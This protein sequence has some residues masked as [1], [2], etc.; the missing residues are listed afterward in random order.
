M[1]EEQQ[2]Q[3]LRRSI[4]VRKPSQ[5]VNTKIYFN[6]NAVIHPIQATCSLA[7]YPQE[8]VV[9]ISNLDQEYIPRTY[10]E[11]MELEEWRD[12]V[13]DEI[14]AMIKNDT[15]YETELPKGKKA[16]H[17]VSSQWKARKKEYKASRNRIHSDLWRRLS[18]YLCSSG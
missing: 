10:Q 12:S 4:R 5:W 3:P 8:H 2:I 13:G 18:G 14:N 9:F 6:I 11:A 15:W 16:H 7:S 17:Q 1:V